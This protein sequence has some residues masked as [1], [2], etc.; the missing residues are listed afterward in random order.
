MV[1]DKNAFAIFSASQKHSD[2]ARGMWGTPVGAGFC[3]FVDGKFEVHCFGDSVTLN[4]KARPEDEV[5]INTALR[6]SEL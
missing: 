2:M 4:L 6:F 5:I 1:T 3:T